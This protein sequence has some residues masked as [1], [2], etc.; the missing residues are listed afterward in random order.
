MTD[1]FVLRAVPFF[2]ARP[3]TIEHS[4]VLRKPGRLA[5]EDRATLRKILDE[6]LGE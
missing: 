2:Q 6:I 1:L 5:E 4:L 3:A